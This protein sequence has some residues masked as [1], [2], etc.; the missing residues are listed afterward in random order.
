[1]VRKLTLLVA[2]AV[3]ATGCYTAFDF[4]GDAKADLYYV[5]S[6]NGDWYRLESNGTGTFLHAGEG[7]AAPGDYDGNGHW[8]IASEANGH[9]VT[10]GD[11][12]TILWPRP[13]PSA[14]QV[15]VDAIEADYD[16]D[17]KTDPAYY[18]DTTATWFIEG[19][20]STVFGTTATSPGS[21]LGYG[22]DQ[23]F[24]V[25]ADYDGDGKA[26]LATWNPRTF[27]WTI[28]SSKTG[29][30]SSA[31]FGAGLAFPVPADYDGDHQADRAYM[32]WDSF[33]HVVQFTIEGSPS[34]TFS[35]G[36]LDSPYP[37]VADFDGDG[38]AD[39]AY[40]NLPLQAGAGHPTPWQIRRS[41]DGVTVDLTIPASS[42]YVTPSMVDTDLIINTARI[43][44]AVR[45]H[46][47][48]ATWC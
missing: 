7:F 31:T 16:G 39:P 47:Q 42:Q 12:G 37:A 6:T 25:P 1:M 11:A 27:L 36:A 22:N 17:H 33:N 23:D 15:H 44:L 14:G 2:I 40:A 28:R 18:D 43:T 30:T 48:P 19:Q 3:V 35:T 5:E 20:S 29:T 21:S 13:T 4:E 8:E 45:C 10:T 38:K 24:P 41:S 9:W 32:N 26:V 46:Y 34:V